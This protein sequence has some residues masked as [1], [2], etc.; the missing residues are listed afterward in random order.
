V[1]AIG[2]GTELDRDAYDGDDIRWVLHTAAA[3]LVDEARGGGTSSWR[4]SSRPAGR[5]ILTWY[6]RSPFSQ[7]SATAPVERS[8]VSRWRSGTAL[9]C[10][11]SSNG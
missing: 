7:I 9:A 5:T 10:P 8:P 1:L 11:H 4:M 2:D 3:D 6:T